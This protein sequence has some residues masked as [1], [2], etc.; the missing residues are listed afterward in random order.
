[1]FLSP[2]S[3]I[4]VLSHLLLVAI[5]VILTTSTKLIPMSTEIGTSITAAGVAGIVIFVY[6]RFADERS[7][8]VGILR[9]FGFKGAFAG[10]SARIRDE[11][12]SRLDRA[13]KQID[14]MGFGLNALREDYQDQF[15]QLSRRARVRVLLIDPDSPY[16]D[17]RDIEERQSRGQIRSEVRDFIRSTAELCLANDRFQIRLYRCLPS[18]NVFRIDDEL[19]WGPYLM[20]ENSRNSPTFLVE[21]GKVLFDSLAQHFDRIWQSDE[22]SRPVP[23]EWLDEE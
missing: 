19:F 22:M 16:A 17:Q 9:D 13:R 11:Y 1:M 14:V 8:A 3:I 6:V 20:N 12:D 7:R 23:E 5:G 4:Y 21:S 10:R 2:A 15:G 18:T